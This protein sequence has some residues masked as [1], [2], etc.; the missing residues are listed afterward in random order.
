MIWS[1]LTTLSLPACI[2][3]ARLGHDLAARRVL[4][5]GICA[6]LLLPSCPRRT[7]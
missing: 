7:P 3:L 2:A 4:L 6:A 5:V 1:A